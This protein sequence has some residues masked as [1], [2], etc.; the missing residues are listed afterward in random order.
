MQ[1]VQQ[2][3]RHQKPV[4]AA[5]VFAVQ[6]DLPIA[7]GA[8]LMFDGSS[9]VLNTIPDA[10]FTGIL[11]SD[12]QTAYQSL[13]TESRPYPLL[14]GSVSV[15][16]ETLQPPQPLFIF[17]G[18]PDAFPVISLAKQLGWH[19]TVI[20]HRE[21]FA[22][23]Q[24]FPEADRVIL[25][26]DEPFPKSV[27]IDERT[28][29]VV[30]THH[31]LTDKKILLHLMR[32]PAAY[33]GILGPAKRAKQL[34]DEVRNKLPLTCEITNR[35]YSPVG[36]DIGAETAEEIALSVIAEIMAVLRGRE[37]G[38]LRER[39]GPIHQR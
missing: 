9:V 10:K 15:L 11:E 22:D 13:S 20:E 12:A 23:P 34:L 18:G 4:V 1:R 37:G 29:C 24:R 21:P 8:R 16:I 6:G 28:V 26:Q 17:G 2:D 39:R 3:I 35:I 7:P 14:G 33:I 38:S 30:M 27:P 31:Y 32:S 5:T 36:L 25:W 19:I